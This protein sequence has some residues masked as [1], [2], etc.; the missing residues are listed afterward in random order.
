MNVVQQALQNLR[1][2]QQLLGMFIF[3]LVAI[4]VWIVVSVATS[5]RSSAI[6]AELRAMALP[7]TPSI[8]REVLEGVESE[9]YFSEEELRNF[10]VV[11]VVEPLENIP[12]PEPSVQPSPEEEPVPEPTEIPSVEPL[13]SEQPATGSATN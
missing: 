6:S 2:R 8:N 13:P 7:L 10:D 4:M 9:R 11:H 1:Q 12:S 3:T 5:Q